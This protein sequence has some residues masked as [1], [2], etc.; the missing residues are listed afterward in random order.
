MA[1]VLFVIAIL[2]TNANHN[3]G[4]RVDVLSARR[5]EPGTVETFTVSVRDTAGKV[6]SVAVDFGD[7][8]VDHVDFADEPCKAP[9]TRTFDLPHKFDFTGYS[10]VAA[11]VVTGGCGAPTERV[12]AIRTIEVREVRR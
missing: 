11:T 7:G 3:H 12:E 8:P 9:M 2:A 4:L 1:V 6:Q 10:T 5:T